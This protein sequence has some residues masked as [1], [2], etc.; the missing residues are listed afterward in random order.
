VTQ[1]RV[2]PVKDTVKEGMPPFPLGYC[3][4]MRLEL[5]SNRFQKTIRNR[6]D[7]GFTFTAMRWRGNALDPARQNISDLN[8]F[9]PNMF[10]TQPPNK[11]WHW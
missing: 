2:N 8:A 6:F 3:N 1:A 9:E 7:T 11:N 4:T 10:R 5:H